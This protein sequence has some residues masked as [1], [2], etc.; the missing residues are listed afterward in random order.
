MTNQSERSYSM[1]EIIE[2]LGV[3]RETILKWITNYGM[4]ATKAG[5]FWKF[6]RTEIE[7][8]VDFLENQKIPF[9]HCL[10]N[11]LFD[12]IW[13]S[14]GLTYQQHSDNTYA[15][16][17]IGTC[18]DTHIV[19][20]TIYLGCP[21][22][23]IEK[24]AF[25][26][27]DHIEK[28]TVSNMVEVIE[29]SAFY[30]CKNLKSVHIPRSVYYIGDSAFQMCENLTDVC[31]EIQSLGN[32]DDLDFDISTLTIGKYA[33]WMTNIDHFK[34]SDK[35]ANIG[36]YAF[37]GCNNLIFYSFN[38]YSYFEDEIKEWDANWDFKNPLNNEKHNVKWNY[39]QT[40]LENNDSSINTNTGI[41]E[42]YELSRFDM[43]S[44]IDYIKH[45]FSNA[46]NSL[47]SWLEE[48]TIR[49][50][51]GIECESCTF[52]E[53]ANKLGVFKEDMVEL[54]N[55]VKQKALRKLRHPSRSKVLRNPIIEIILTAFYSD[56]LKGYLRLY[57]D[58]FGDRRILDDVEIRKN[59]WEQITDNTLL[60]DLSWHSWMDDFECNVTV[61]ELTKLTGKEVYELC[62]ENKKLFEE[63]VTVLYT[64]QKVLSDFAND[65]PLNSYIESIWKTPEQIIS[66][67]LASMKIEELDLSIRTF[68][69]LK[70]AG[71]LTVG[72]IAS[73]TFEDMCRVRNLGRKSLEEV[74]ARIGSLGLKLRE[75]DD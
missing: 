75:S 15:V 61:S 2:H 25:R 30:G 37:G 23:R 12:N 36:A 20:P 17:G 71:I 53:I 40:N 68:N 22:T 35:I 56:E 59:N 52:E 29:H 60:S 33:F 39:L 74:I 69:L 73:R 28:V 57:A 65:K 34:I 51:Y 42:N 41:L 64:K 6:K 24:N 10:R 13:R 48:T 7:A 18:R 9:S 19:I 5:R 70:R 27:I 21:V 31:F 3:N 45:I 50:I 8:W 32:I 47:G 54:E 62:K 66:E 44:N 67:Q 4:P 55:T 16:T 43:P 11:R 49:H 1:V 26:E 38:D 63:I 14:I 72:D 58:I 46:L